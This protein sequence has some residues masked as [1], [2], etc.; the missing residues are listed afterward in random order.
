MRFADR[1]PENQ[2]NNLSVELDKYKSTQAPD[3]SSPTQEVVPQDEVKQTYSTNNLPKSVQEWEDLAI[4]NPNQHADLRFH[5]N[6][7]AQTDE[8][9]F[10]E[11]QSNSRRVVQGE[12]PDMYLVELDEGGQPKKDDKGKAIL[13]VDQ[14]TGEPIFDPNSEKGKL[15]TDIYNKNPNIASNAQAP[16]LMMAAME[17]QLRVKGEE[18]VD[19][20]KGERD[21]QVQEGQVVQEGVTPPAKVEVTFKDDEEKVHAERMVKRGAYQNLEEYVKNRDS[22]DTALY[23][24]NS[25]PVFTKK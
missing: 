4:E 2:R 17:R 25:M 3:T 13:K 20:A 6:Q 24:E 15:W 7:R 5:Y 22:K 14:Q 16:E 1:R 10:N 23:E 9:S 11:T 18:M 19:E 8:S 12:H 21:Q